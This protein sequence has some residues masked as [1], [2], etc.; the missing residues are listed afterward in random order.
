MAGVAA[1]LMPRFRCVDCCCGPAMVLDPPRGV[2]PICASC[3]A[4]LTRQAR[5]RPLGLVVLL[6]VGSVLVLGS[7]P[8]LVE[9]RPSQPRPGPTESTS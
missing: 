2:T 9:P 3:G 8:L 6:A 4:P 5:V 7:V 1:D